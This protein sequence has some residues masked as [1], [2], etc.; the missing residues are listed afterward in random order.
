MGQRR[1]EPVPGYRHLYETFVTH[2]AQLAQFWGVEQLCI[3]TE[4]QATQSREANWR[5]VV[6]AARAVY[7]G[8]LTY[9]A[10][11]D[12]PGEAVTWWDALDTIGVSAYY[13]LTGEN[14]PILDELRA[15]WT[16]RAEVLSDLSAA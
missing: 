8:S 10:N 11:H 14:D 9:S 7:S 6:A 1:R 5:D 12:D 2:Y 4:L 13:Q 16:S 3:G 15:A